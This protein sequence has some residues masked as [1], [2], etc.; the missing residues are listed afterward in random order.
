MWRRPTQIIHL[1]LVGLMAACQSG[2]SSSSQSPSSTPQGGR[3]LADGITRTRIAGVTFEGLGDVAPGVPG[4]PVT[5]Q[6]IGTV[7]SRP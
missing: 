2:A 1:L 6:L 4:S 7:P 5:G 3:A